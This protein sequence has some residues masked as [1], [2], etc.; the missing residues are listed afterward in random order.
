M[1]I[2]EV[3]EWAT[4]L[5]RGGPHTTVTERRL[6]KTLLYL[7][8]ESPPANYRP[9]IAGTVVSP[10]GHPIVMASRITANVLIAATPKEIR[11]AAA[12]L[13][14]TAEQVEAEAE[15]AGSLSR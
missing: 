5:S 4:D 7:L 9:V 2:S 10:L 6:A 11:G 13:L 3:L 14:R 15:A 8:G 1:K 12:I